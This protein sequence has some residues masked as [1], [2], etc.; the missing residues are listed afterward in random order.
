MLLLLFE[1]GQEVRNELACFANLPH[2]LQL[3]NVHA[4]PQVAQVFTLGREEPR[5]FRRMFGTEFGQLH[6][7]GPLAGDNP[8]L[9]REFVARQPHGFLGGFLGHAIDFE[10][11]GARL[12]DRHEMVDRAFAATHADL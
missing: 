8:R 5:E 6:T 4:K 7:L 11:N 3:P 10:Q 12:H 9:D 2:V 1:D